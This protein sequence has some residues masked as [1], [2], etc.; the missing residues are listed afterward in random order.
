[1]KEKK[2]KKVIGQLHGTKERLKRYSHVNKKA[3]EQFEQFDHQRV[4]LSARKADLDASEAHIETLVE[5]LDERKTEA[6]ERTFKQVSAFFTDIF[7][8]LVPLGKGTLTILRADSNEDDLE[9]Y[10]EDDT[11]EKQEEE[12]EVEE[13]EVEEEEEEDEIDADKENEGQR[14]RSRT[15]T[16]SIDKTQNVDKKKKAHLTSSFSTATTTKTKSKAKKKRTATK[17][18]AVRSEPYKGVAINV[19]SFLPFGLQMDARWD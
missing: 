14:R 17:K 1:M 7:K 3:A 2:K 16:K 8:T 18:G 9:Q 11:L 15:Q 12:N 13:E 5:H 6:M 19:F 4:E 10:D